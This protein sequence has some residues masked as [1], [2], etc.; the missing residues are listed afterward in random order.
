[1]KGLMSARE[2]IRN[3][4]QKCSGNKPKRIADKW[5]GVPATALKEKEGMS[6]PEGT[7]CL[8]FLAGANSSDL[9]S[10]NDAVLLGA[11]VWRG[12]KNKQTGLAEMDAVRMGWLVFYKAGKSS[13]EQFK[14]FRKNDRNTVSC[15]L[16]YSIWSTELLKTMG[17]QHLTV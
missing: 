4:G 13:G 6:L 10:E 3:W 7:V 5:Q 15:T 9:P 8:A 1:M 11:G 12:V 2:N 17:M 14:K 16:W